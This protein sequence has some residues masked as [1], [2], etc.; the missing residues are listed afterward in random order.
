SSGQLDMQGVEPVV[1][2][3]G[4]AG[5]YSMDG[6]TGSRSPGDGC[7]RVNLDWCV[8]HDWAGELLGHMRIYIGVNRASG[9]ISRRY[10][11]AET[12]EL[13]AVG[14]VFGLFPPVLD[15]S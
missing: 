4:V 5:P 3:V 13:L 9:V 10:S 7:A 6:P 14:T 12:M 8:R 11:W 15:V 1:G 2:V